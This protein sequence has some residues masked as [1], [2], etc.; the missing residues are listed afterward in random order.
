MERSLLSNE[1]SAA[2]RKTNNS[3]EYA[4]Y[5][6][7]K[8][9][10]LH[11]IIRIG[12]T[13]ISIL[14]ISLF[15]KN[16]SNNAVNLSMMSINKDTS[17]LFNAM[18]LPS[19]SKDLVYSKLE[20][21]G[22]HLSDIGEE[23]LN[24]NYTE[25]N[26]KNYKYSKYTYKDILLS[27]FVSKENSEIE[28]N[29][30]LF[31]FLEILKKK[32]INTFFDF[33][34]NFMILQDLT[35]LPVNY[36]GIYINGKFFI[37]NYLNKVIA[38]DLSQIKTL[39]HE[40]PFLYITYHGGKKKNAIHNICKYSRDG[41]YL[42][43]ILLPFEEDGKIFNAISLRGL[44][45]HENNLY[46]T[47]SFK[48][49][50]KIFQFSNS[51]PELSNRREYISTFITQDINNNPLMIHPYGIKKFNDYFYISSQNTGTVLRFHIN[52]GMLGEPSD[53]FKDIAKG[54]VVKLGKNEEIRGI[55]F[56]NFGNCYVSNKQ[57][58]VQIYD[59]NF[60]LIKILPVFSPISVLFDNT[61]NHIL[62]GSSK[63]HDIKEYDIN[64]FE[65]IKVIKHPLLKHVAGISIHEDSAFVVSQRKNKL[66]EFSLSTSLLKNIVVDN[67][68]DVGERVI[69][70]PT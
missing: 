23:E 60:N 65:I 21:W 57:V 12:I 37:S 63:T 19:N 59:T 51:I 32:E 69:L 42:G 2:K 30:L 8:S 10:F 31:T 53:S 9:K 20:N 52:N 36:K 41:Y 50:S 25:E 7:P 28:K 13:F 14:V 62:V 49:N 6:L 3:N 58:G 18:G 44:L 17:D 55:D 54:L 24:K 61:R 43:S 38:S 70:V 5:E 27:N 40:Q 1:E 66:L 68:S 4:N 26:I 67:F 46:V 47:D 15:V 22:F 33:L 34:N 45:L 35:C 64:N 16:N 29:I 56:D 39:I 48:E 11:L